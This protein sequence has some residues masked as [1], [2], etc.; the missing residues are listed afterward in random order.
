LPVENIIGH[1]DFGGLLADFLNL[2]CTFSHKRQRA[3]F[4]SWKKVCI[5]RSPKTKKDNKTRIASTRKI[6]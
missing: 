5:K 1:E 4:P 2:R 6:K 3:V